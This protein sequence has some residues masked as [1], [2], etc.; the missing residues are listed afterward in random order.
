MQN[1]FQEVKITSPKEKNLRKDFS[2]NFKQALSRKYS[3]NSNAQIKTDKNKL[4]KS[5]TKIT[6]KKSKETSKAVIKP[7]LSNNEINIQNK[8][9]NTTN[10]KYLNKNKK[11]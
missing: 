8:N 9:K 3:K 10:N 4:N 2:S 6:I 5:N 1:A 7:Y 11:K